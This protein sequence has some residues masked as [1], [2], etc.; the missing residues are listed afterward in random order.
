MIWGGSLFQFLLCQGTMWTQL[1]GKNYSSR[2][3]GVGILECILL[4]WFFLVYHTLYSHS[5]WLFRTPYQ[6]ARLESKHW[7]HP[8]P[9]NIW[10][11]YISYSLAEGL[12][13]S[14][15]SFSS[16]LQHTLPLRLFGSVHMYPRPFRSERFPQWIHSVILTLT[17]NESGPF[18]PQNQDFSV[19]KF[20]PSLLP[21]S[22]HELSLHTPRTY[23]I[24]N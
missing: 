19:P 17:S 5:S 21:I 24:S 1:P 14:A 7:H 23:L 12:E 22:F 9:S 13:S 4:K 3:I 2:D 8:P 20:L 10:V 16:P 6:Q 11:F 18:P 15:L